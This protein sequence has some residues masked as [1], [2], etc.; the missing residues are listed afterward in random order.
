MPRR[1]ES[2]VKMRVL[3]RFAF[4]LLA[5]AFVCGWQ[6]R[7]QARREGGWGIKPVG[8]GV[9]T[10]VLAGLGGLA[11]RQRHARPDDSPD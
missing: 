6:A 8:Y 10:V 4:T 3:S 1:L 7:E 5:L 9:A 2:P 11:L